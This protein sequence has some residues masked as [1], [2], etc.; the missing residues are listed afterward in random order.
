[1]YNDIVFENNSKIEDMVN[2]LVLKSLE[3]YL[4]PVLSDVHLA[5]QHMAL[6]LTSLLQVFLNIIWTFKGYT[7]FTHTAYKM[8]DQNTQ[9][10][11]ICWR[12]WRL[13]DSK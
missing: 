3:I 4:I 7:F 11:L 8:E 12:T 10:S 13:H 5:L 6:F 2:I 1:M 9:E